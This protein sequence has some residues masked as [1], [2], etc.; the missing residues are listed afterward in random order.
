MRRALIISLLLLSGNI[1]C[2][3][4][5]IDSG[6]FTTYDVNNAKT[7]LYWTVCGSIPPGEGCYSSGQLGP[8]GKIGSIV[9]NGKSY[10][11]TAGTVTRLVFI[12]DQAYGSAGTSVALY[13]YKRDDTIFGSSDTTTFTLQK[14]VPLPLTGGNS[15]LIFLAANSGYAVIGSSLTSTTYEIKKGTYV[16]TP[17]TIIS[18][19]PISITPDN[20]GYIT[21]TLTGGFFVVGPNGALQEDGGGSP[22]SVNTLLGTRP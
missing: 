14:T 1:V 11:L 10:N 13:V 19:T 20:Y 17:L 9:E 22:F 3:A 21:V 2:Y 15:A 6:L 16:I 8:F 7:M 12:V 5:Q 4:A 18:G